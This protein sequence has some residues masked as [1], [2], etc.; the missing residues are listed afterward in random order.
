[1]LSALSSPS[2]SAV[3]IQP[4]LRIRLR[5]LLSVQLAPTACVKV[6]RVIRL[7]RTGYALRLM[8]TVPLSADALCQPWRPP[9]RLWVHLDNAPGSGLHLSPTGLELDQQVIGLGR[10]TTLRASAGETRL[11]GSRGHTRTQTHTH[12]PL[13][14]QQRRRR[15]SSGLLP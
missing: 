6:S 15:R 9:A 8:Y 3:H 14:A 4:R 2:S 11:R 13:R 7:W 12:T 1:M 5:D 10:T